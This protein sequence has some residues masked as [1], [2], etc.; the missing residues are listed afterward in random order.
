MR[1]LITGGCGFVGRHFIE[2]LQSLASEIV[3]VD[4]LIEGGGGLPPEKWYFR[5]YGNVRFLATDCRDFFLVNHGHFDL[6]IHLAAVVGGRL[7]IERNPLA[8]ADDLAI[9]ANFWKWAIANNPGHIISFSSSAAYPVSLQNDSPR[10]LTEE[11]IDF[12]DSLGVPDLTYGWAKLTNEYIGRL[13]ARMYNLKVA[14]YRPFSGYG[15]DQSLS[16]PFPSICLRAIEKTGSDSFE[17]WGSGLQQ[18]DFIHID[19]IVDAVLH[20]YSG[21]ADGSSINLSSGQGTS[22]IELASLACSQLGYNPKVTGQTNMPEGVFSR[23]GDN[24]K[25]L[26]LGWKAKISL[27]EGI[28]ECIRYL[29][30]AKSQG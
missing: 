7:T 3:V 8:V 14:S 15:P 18:R 10:K 6:V 5:P 25:L 23:I 1:V 19:D 2:K 12:E 16:Y 27:P 21:I 28:E 24:S 30:V 26:S 9:D 4:N 22:F 20:T 11:D 29:Q 13:A 17:V